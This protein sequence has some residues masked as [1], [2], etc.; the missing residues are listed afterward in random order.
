MLGLL[1]I[2][3]CV[4]ACAENEPEGQAL[5]EEMLYGR[6]ELS[7]ATRNG[8]PTETL[9][10]TFFEFAEE[11]QMINNLAGSREN[12]NY[13]FSGDDMLIRQTDGRMPTDYSITSFTDSTLTLEMD[14]RNIPFVLTLAKQ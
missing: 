9:N 2:S 10:T 8:Q 3:F 6:W 7:S 14:L 1:A 4:L 12:V 13:E 11:G 5:T